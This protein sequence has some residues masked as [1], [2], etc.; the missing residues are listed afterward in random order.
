[1]NG[2]KEIVKIHTM[3]G[4]IF[5]LASNHVIRGIMYRMAVIIGKISPDRT[6]WTPTRSGGVR[7][8]LKGKKTIM[9][10]ILYVI[11]YVSV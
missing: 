8:V 4:F 1:M 5:V 9:T 7:F 6:N 11:P 2:D 3:L 10:A